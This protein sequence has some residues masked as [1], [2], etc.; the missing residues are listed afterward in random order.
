MK[1]D[2]AFFLIKNAYFNIFFFFIYANII[3]VY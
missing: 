3:K 2:K 1:K